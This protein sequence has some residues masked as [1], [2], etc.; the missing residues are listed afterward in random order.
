MSDNI[1]NLAD[2]ILVLTYGEMIEMA[3]ELSQ[4]IAD[5]EIWPSFGTE[6]DF[7]ALLHGWAE[8]Q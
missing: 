1:K 8:A 5:K 2:A 6:K 7:A 3:G 4:G